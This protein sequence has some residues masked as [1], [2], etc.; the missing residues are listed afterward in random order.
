MTLQRVFQNGWD[1]DI[2]HS[3]RQS[4]VELIRVHY[5]RDFLS[6]L[7]YIEYNRFRF[8]D[9][10]LACKMKALLNPITVKLYLQRLITESKHLHDAV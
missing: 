2:Y 1:I 10:N 7:I 4:N 5:N 9:N 3:T 6:Y 8:R